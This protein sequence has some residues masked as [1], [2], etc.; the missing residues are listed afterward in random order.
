MEHNML[1]LDFWQDTVTYEDHTMPI[2]TIGCAALNIPDAII[3]RLDVLCE[4]MNRFLKTLT[5]G[6]P[7]S[8]LLPEAKEAAKEILKLLH[9]VPPFDCLDM[10]F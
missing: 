5:A 1:S 4:P 2:G 10:D 6:T 7:D 3:D 8:A 9:P